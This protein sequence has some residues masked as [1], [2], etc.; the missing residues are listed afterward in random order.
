MFCHNHFKNKNFVKNGITM[1]YSNH[2]ASLVIDLSL[3]PNE[4]LNQLRN[5]RLGRNTLLN[6]LKSYEKWYKSYDVAFNI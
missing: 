3:N 5:Y 2:L 1:M 4:L 6:I